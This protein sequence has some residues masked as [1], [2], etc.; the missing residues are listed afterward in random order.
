MK[1]L[2]LLLPLSLT[3]CSWHYGT[4]PIRIGP[5]YY[6]VVCPDPPPDHQQVIVGS[7]PCVLREHVDPPKEAQQ[8]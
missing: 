2:I 8:P 4:D 5:K 6:D 3:G 1:L 7:T